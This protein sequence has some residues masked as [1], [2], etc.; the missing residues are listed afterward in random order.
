MY[1]I[2]SN[3]P[4]KLKLSTFCMYLYPQL[5]KTPHDCTLHIQNKWQTESWGEVGLM[6]GRSSAQQE[7]GHLYTKNIT[8]LN[9]NIILLC[10]TTIVCNTAVWVSALYI[11]DCL[12]TTTLASLSERNEIMKHI[13]IGLGHCLGEK[14]VRTNNIYQQH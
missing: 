2:T 8:T 9:N 14:I 10:I 11:H 1:S 6:F 4:L 5:N 13:K 3:C 7:R 12:I